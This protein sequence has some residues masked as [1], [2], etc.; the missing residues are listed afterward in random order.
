MRFLC[1]ILLLL[2]MFLSGQSRIGG[3][4]SH[5]SFKPVILVEEMPEYIVAATANGIFLVSKRDFQI[6]TKTRVEGLSDTGITAISYANEPDFLLIGYQ[7][8]NLDIFHNGDII[9][10][11]DLTRKAGLPDKT[12]HRI[13]CE[14]STAYLCCAFGVV[15]IDLKKMEV[16]ETWYLSTKDHLNEAFDLISY[17]GFWWIATGNG[18]CKAEKQNTNLQDY[19]NWQ[20]QTNLQSPNALF[21]SLVQLDGVLIAHDITNDRILAFNGIIWQPW[22][23]DVKNI[24]KIKSINNVVIVITVNDIR[25]FS[26]IGNE[27]ING[28]GQASSPMS[29][30]DAL[31]S[32]T[33]E[34]WI[35]DTNNGLTRRISNSSFL[36]YIPNSPESDL[37]S[38]LNAGSDEIFAGTY[39]LNSSGTPEASYSIRQSGIWQN[40]NFSDDPG[41]KSIR[42]ITSFAISANHPGE[43]WASTAGSGLLLFQKNR[44][45][46]R[47][48]EQNS[49]LGAQNN[50][51]LVNGVSLDAQNNLW[52]TNPT[53]K[54]LLG[55]CSTSG[56]FVSLPFP[57]IEQTSLE[58]GKIL[59]TSSGTHWVTLADEGLFAFKT[60]G[61]AGNVSFDQSR[62]VAVQSLFSNS[63]TTLTTR[64]SGISTLTEDLSHRLWVGTSN[65]VVVYNDPE[66]IF[67]P[68]EFFGTQPSLND[69][70]AIFKPILEKEII[71]SIAVD[72]GNRKW[73]GT[74]ASGIFLFSEQ[75]DHLLKHFNSK[76]SPLLS[77]QLISIAI[78]QKS[79]EVFF[80]TSRGLISFVGDATTAGTGFE[81]AYV[82]P[83]PLREY[84]EGGVTIDGLEEGTDLRITDLAGNLLFH[85]TSVGGRSVWN[86]RNTHGSRVSTGVYL[87]ICSS[88]LSG[89]SKILKLLV[90]H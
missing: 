5:V 80:A 57:I 74:A 36:H 77:D 68:G 86:A 45:A 61:S 54:A 53:G 2:P 48:S 27:V 49:L 41:L 88:P 83:N 85:T 43:Y 76:N 84:F 42:P 38:A 51:C 21:S 16:S 28:V 29:P 1:S 9:N 72:G 47:F 31:Y 52:Y 63:T 26:K 12:I 70:E 14:G 79:G 7:S 20:F 40:F 60:K 44:V 71:T 90:I 67:S 35:A 56:S 37:I 34:Y 81:K 10:I 25:I 8:G 69:G 17:N 58:A 3:W 87:V 30:S 78:D 13:I 75:G 33:S 46:A 39:S 6:T 22:L 32:S 89:S 59:T 62:K 82:W 19:R 66:K 64:F 11:S 65:G 24:R 55:T 50:L 15:K 73:I 18:I 23:P 4:R